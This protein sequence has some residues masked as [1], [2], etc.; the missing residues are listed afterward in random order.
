MHY[1]I[2]SLY[3]NPN[4]QGTDLSLENIGIGLFI[5]MYLDKNSM[6]GL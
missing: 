2:Y 4:R 6:H 5:N 3:D 1:Y